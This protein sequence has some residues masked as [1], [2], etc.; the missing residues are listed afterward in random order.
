MN[1]NTLLITGATGNNGTELLK[2]LASRGVS[3]RAM[4]RPSSD[5]GA[6][7]ALSGVDIVEGDFDNPES[8]DRI[9]H[10]VDRAFLLTNSTERAESQQLRFVEAAQRNGVKHIVKLSQLGAEVDSPVRF[11]HYH[12]VVEN[13][14]RASGM[15]FTFLRP[16]LYMQGLLL[17]K[18]SIIAQGKFFAPA[19]DARVSSVDVRDIAAAAATALTESG[20]AG[21]TYTLTGPEALTH[22]EM[23]DA[24]SQAIGKPIAFVDIPSE[25]MREA[26]L[27]MGMPAWQADGLIEDFAHYRRGEASAV[28]TGILDATGQ[29]PRSFAQFVY[30]YAGAFVG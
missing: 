12:A 8:L 3:A 27:T 22:A 21:K 7:S 29:P 4:V 13:A 19:G 11:L 23:A 18:D 20:H 6:L 25:A 14:I 1:T 10:G 24:L 17:F 28:E 26:V 2:L 30:D 16:N 5:T 9:L 15:D